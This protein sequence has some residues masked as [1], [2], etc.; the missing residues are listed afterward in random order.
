MANIKYFL[1]YSLL[2]LNVICIHGFQNNKINKKNKSICCENCNE[3][4]SS[5]NI[6]KIESTVFNNINI[7]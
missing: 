2:I 3:A 1:F 7:Q 6:L 5:E 4:Y